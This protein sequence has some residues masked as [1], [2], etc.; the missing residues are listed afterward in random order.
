MYG[1]QGLTGGKPAIKGRPARSNRNLDA[2]YRR[3]EHHP[4]GARGS[5]GQQRPRADAAN[6]GTGKSVEPDSR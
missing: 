5:P 4:G 6:R 1:P 3:T 2:A